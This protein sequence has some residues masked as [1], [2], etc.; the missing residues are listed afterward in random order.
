MPSE[1][2]KPC[3]NRN[4][5]E[6]Q[7]LTNET[8]VLGGFHHLTHDCHCVQP[9]TENVFE[10]A[11]SAAAWPA[12]NFNIGADCPAV[13]DITNDSQACQE[14]YRLNTAYIEIYY[15]QLNFES[16]KETAGY[17]VRLD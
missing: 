14:Y 10:T 4:P 12:L 5:R 6:R 17:T 11:Y 13:L 9:C 2:E 8:T 1:K 16:L 3:D 7:C 15:E